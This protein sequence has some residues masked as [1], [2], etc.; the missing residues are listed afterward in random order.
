MAG[1]G[2]TDFTRLFRTAVHQWAVW[3]QERR[4]AYNATLPIAEIRDRR[5]CRLHH[6]VREVANGLGVDADN[7]EHMQAVG[8]P[9]LPTRGEAG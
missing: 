7:L 8:W 6:I 2:D 5:E 1:A 3:E 9:P 4:E